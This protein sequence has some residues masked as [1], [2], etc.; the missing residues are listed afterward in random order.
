[1]QRHTWT[2]V[3]GSNS[4]V[5]PC[6]CLWGCIVRRYQWLLC[7][8]S[9]RS[10]GQVSDTLKILFLGMCVCACAFWERKANK[11]CVALSPNTAINQGDYKPFFFFP[12]WQCADWHGIFI[13]KIN[14]CHL[15]WIT[16]ILACIVLW[17]VQWLV[18]GVWG[19]CFATLL[20]S[21]V[22]LQVNFI[23]IWQKLLLCFLFFF[24]FFKP[25]PLQ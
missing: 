7:A 19:L 17:R 13:N 5:I 16:Q 2:S 9:G 10:S 22:S 11:V 4:I 24:F 3:Y 14:P 15:H 25:T 8:S 6:V 1:M 23:R 18:C 20:L 12:T 21:S